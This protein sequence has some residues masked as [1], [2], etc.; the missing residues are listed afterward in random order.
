MLLRAKQQTVFAL[1]K[2]MTSLVSWYQRDFFAFWSKAEK[3][4]CF[5]FKT[6]TL[7]LHKK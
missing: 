1:T 6:M 4:L 3:F 5:A 2:S 7:S